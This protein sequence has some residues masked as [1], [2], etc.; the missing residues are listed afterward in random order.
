MSLP[1]TAGVQLRVRDFAVDDAG[2]HQ[3]LVR[4]FSDNRAVIHDDD[5][6]RL[7]DCSDALRDQKRR[8]AFGGFLQL[9]AQGAVR[10][11]IQRGKGIIEDIQLRLPIDGPGNGDALLLS[12]GDI[13]A[14]RR[15]AESMP[16]GMASVKSC[17]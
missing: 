17:A 3:L 12:A 1:F 16:S 10:L 13:D 14:P 8:D 9:G 4:P 2:L 11:V 6:V 15:I 7:E 5:P